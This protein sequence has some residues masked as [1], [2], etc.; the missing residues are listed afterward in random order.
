M[1]SVHIYNEEA[2][3]ASPHLAPLFDN[4]VH[5]FNAGPEWKTM[6]LYAL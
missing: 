6:T 1:I 5:C 4:T 3:T 2:P